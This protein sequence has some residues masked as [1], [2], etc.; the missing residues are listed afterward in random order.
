MNPTQMNTL[1]IIKN[2]I[3]KNKGISFAS[4]FTAPYTQFNPNGVD[5]I[6]GKLADEVFE[7][8]APFKVSVIS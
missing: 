5:G 4:L 2:D 3:A 1:E 6:F 8:I 7:L